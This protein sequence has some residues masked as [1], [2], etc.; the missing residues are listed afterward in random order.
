MTKKTDIEK[1]LDLTGQSFQELMEGSMYAGP[2][3]VISELVPKALREKKKIVWV[4]EDHDL[5]TGHYKLVNP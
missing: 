4:A 2:D 3:Y 5:A 1:Y